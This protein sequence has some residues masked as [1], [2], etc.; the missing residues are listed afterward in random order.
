MANSVNMISK[1]SD[2]STITK[3]LTDINPAVEDIKVA[4]F[5]KAVA[6]LSNNTLTGIQKVVKSTLNVNSSIDGTEGAETITSSDYAATVDAKGGNDT[7]ILKG[8]VKNSVNAGTGD[9][10]ISI[11]ADSSKNSILGSEGNDTVKLYG[12]QNNISL[13]GGD[14]AVTLYSSAK[15]NTL[16][17]GTGNDSVYFYDGTQANLASLGA[18]NNYVTVNG[19]AAESIIGGSGNDN[20]YLNNSRSNNIS[21]NGGD[22]TVSIFGGD[23]N[24]IIGGAGNNLYFFGGDSVGGTNHIKNF[25]AAKDTLKISDALYTAADTVENGN[26]QLSLNKDSLSTNAV[27]HGV[28][29][30][31]LNILVGDSNN[32]RAQYKIGEG[33]KGVELNNTAAGVS[34]N[35]GPFDDI[36]S[37]SADSVTIDSGDGSNTISSHADNVVIY[38]NAADS[39]D[40]TGEN[41]TI[42]GDGKQIISITG[43]NHLVKHF[44]GRNTFVYGWTDTDSLQFVDTAYEEIS[45]TAD[46]YSI[47]TADYSTALLQGN[48]S[49]TPNLIQTSYTPEIYVASSSKET[50]LVTNTGAT[51]QKSTGDPKA[52]EPKQANTYFGGLDAGAGA[53]SISIG[54]DVRNKTICGGRGN[55]TINLTA[56]THGNVYQYVYG[57][58]KDVILGWKDNDTIYLPGISVAEGLYYKTSMA[59]DGESLIMYIGPGSI[60]FQDLAYGTQIKVIDKDTQSLEGAA[61]F[62]D[63]VTFRKLMQ[64]TTDSE[65]INNEGASVK[66]GTSAADAWS[67]DGNSGNDTITNTGN[68]V[69]IDGGYGVDTINVSANNGT[70]TSGV[71]ISGGYGNDTID[72]SADIIEGADFKVADTKSGGHVY[73]Y[74]AAAGHGKD[75]IIGFNS[76]DS[77]LIENLDVEYTTAQSDVDTLGN[78]VIR[79]E[80]GSITIKKPDGKELGGTRLNVF[81]ES[82]SPA[83][84][85]PLGTP[86]TQNGVTFYTIPKKLLFSGSSAESVVANTYVGYTVD[87]A[88]GNDTVKVEAA[89]TSIAGGAGDDLISIGAAASNVKDDGSFDS[90]KTV[91]I[92]GGY[93]FDTID[94]SADKKSV[95]SKDVYSSHIYQFGIYDGKDT[96]IGFNEND[97]IQITVHSGGDFPAITGKFDTD[98]KSYVVDVKGATLTLKDYGGG[99]KI[100]LINQANHDITSLVGGTY[101]PVL[102]NGNYI[103]PRYIL[104]TFGS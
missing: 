97:S 25:D 68:Y 65:T 9:N 21:L 14:N 22:N 66:S 92:I 4:R 88:G 11:S 89:G 101:A 33:L 76:N 58:G 71:T 67:I 86:V 37:N 87:A 3:T 28:S 95:N 57:D 31:V 94:V 80:S 83:N 27:I 62:A 8:A 56:S 20:F 38:R 51:A 1:T 6:S 81:K 73:K 44:Y 96:I 98:G 63:T 49:N 15:N 12:F 104:G 19:G 99:K 75:T 50:I 36:I 90:T 34:V 43:G 85:L 84:I 47:L 69:Y 23:N 93:S 102:E 61:R 100:K 54:A 41:I 7:I 16:Y 91:T 59:A 64:G 60:T 46:G 42:Y 74:D 48:F 79:F 10:V 53:D 103:I 35:G 55:D 52:L 30:G 45:L 18:G 26:L 29:S 5:V 24:S 32:N 39:L 2:G 77:I 78:Y 13:G 82:I 72:V 40:V 70:V 17:G